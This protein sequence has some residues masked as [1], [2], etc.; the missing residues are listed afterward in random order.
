VVAP[1]SLLDGTWSAGASGGGG[2]SSGRY[3]CKEIG[4]W[5]KAQE[6]LSQGHTYLDR[7]GDGEVCEALR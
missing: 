5:S 7:D 1:R 6:L 2:N 4:S 3:R